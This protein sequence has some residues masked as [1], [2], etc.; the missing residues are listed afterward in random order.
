M[1]GFPGYKGKFR[2]QIFGRSKGK[3]NLYFPEDQSVRRNVPESEITAPKTPLPNWA[4][5]SRKQFAGQQMEITHDDTTVENTPKV[6]G[7]FEVMSMGKGKNANKYVC[8]RVDKK[9]DKSVYH[10][11]MGYVQKK[12]L[13]DI[14]PIT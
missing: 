14:F 4:K 6:K 13:K 10:I 9:N 7:V 2:A 1:S 5:V 3:Y 11:D 12:L 8:K